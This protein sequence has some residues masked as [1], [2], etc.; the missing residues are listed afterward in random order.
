DV[1]KQAITELY[2]TYPFQ[3]ETNPKRQNLRLAIFIHDNDVSWISSILG[4]DEFN[5]VLRHADIFYNYVSSCETVVQR[6]YYASLPDYR[7][8]MD[9]IYEGAF[10]GV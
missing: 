4:V 7:S 9:G 2:T 5:N 1:V 10:H 6:N 8:Y 3:D